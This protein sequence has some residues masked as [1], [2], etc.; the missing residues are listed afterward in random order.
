MQLVDTTLCFGNWKYS[1]GTGTLWR[2][3]NGVNTD[4]AAPE[5]AVAEPHAI[6]LEPR[7]HTLLNYFLQQPEII[8]SK[9]ALLDAIW[10]D[11][12]G[13]DAA[14]M[15]AIGMLR[16]ALEDSS[17]PATYIETLS[18]RGYRWVAPI[19]QLPQVAHERVELKLKSSVAHNYVLSE[20]EATTA[21]SD[22][23][24]LSASQI[25]RREKQ[26]RLGLLSAF[27]ICAVMALV[28][29]LLLFFGKTNFTPAFNRQIIISAMAGQEQKPLL[30]PDQST[31]FYQQKTSETRWR[32]V[33]HQL[34]SHRKQ[35]HPQLF[36]K[37]SAGQWFEQQLV[38]Q[39]ELNGRCDIYRLAP[40]SP[41]QTAEAWLPCHQLIGHGIASGGKNLLWLDMNAN[42]ASQ[43]WRYSAGKAELQ[44][45]FA[46]AYRRPVAVLSVNEI[47]WVL[48]QQDEFNTS[49]FSFDLSSATL[50]KVAD[51]PY[52]FHTLSDWDGRRLL[53]SGPA[54]S[55]L[56]AVA[57]LQLAALQLASGVYVDQQRVDDR[58]LATQIPRDA[59]DLLPLQPSAGGRS[60]TLLSASPW[61][62]SNKTDQMLSWHGE[63]AALV[64]ER[65]GLPQIWWFDG[66][67]I[68]QLTKFTQWRQITQLLW[69][70]SELYA[71][72]EQQLYL[73]SLKDGSISP[74]MLQERQLR[75]FAVCH[76]QWFW[77][78]FSHQQWQLKTLNRQQQPVELVSDI[79]DVRCAPE[80]S[81]LLLK[82]DGS[83][84]RFWPETNTLLA[85][86]WQLMW[87]QMG[88]NSW[89]TTSQGLYWFDPAGQLWLS[90]WQQRTREAVALPGLLQVTGIYGELEQEQLFLQ[91]ARDTETDVVWLQPQQFQ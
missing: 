25:S 36:D 81:L 29:S 82:Q 1:P 64:S 63:Q 54:G 19:H 5:A 3:P 9:S 27:F 15:R 67:K 60:S 80:Q 86:P 30:S 48:L 14:L 57:D 51:F 49:L 75:H 84:Q 89:T 90:R 2:M 34:G 71:V 70:G 40:G 22:G 8:H 83:V 66:Q 88:M 18:K 38:F 55:Y 33:A 53:L 4:A 20:T 76:R 41:D 24:V 10:G 61:L 79:I 72:I 13:T 73:V 59:A 91:L 85:L 69:S 74:A 43:L 68:S 6:V 58:L 44:Q 65:S 37:L 7:L 11:A 28:I 56:F 87:R 32:W 50:Q 26:R 17:K 52:A 42:G 47:A 21:G 39:G 77:A 12:E 31:L 46:A 45:T 62:S 16:K 78:E 23:K 35:L